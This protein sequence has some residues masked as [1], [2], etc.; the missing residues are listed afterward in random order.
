M[1]LFPHHLDFNFMKY[2]YIS[3]GISL[4]LMIFASIVWFQKGVEK[5]GVEFAGGTELIIQFP[6]PVD[7]ALVRHEIENAGFPSATVQA[8]EDGSHK[9]SIR[10][11]AEPGGDAGKKIR[12][13]LK[14]AWKDTEFNVLDE[15]FVGPTIGEQLRKDGFTAV[16]VSLFCILVYIWVRFDFSFAVG[17]VAALF[18]DTII[19]S[20]LV[21]FFGREV[22]A[23][24]LAAV[25]TIIGYSVNDTV[26]VFDRI[27]ENFNKA[28]KSGGASKKKDK[29][30][31][32]L[33]SLMNASINQTLNRTI[34]T[35]A[36]VSFVCILLWLLGDGAV[37]DLAF[38]LTIGM[39]FGTYSSIFTAAPI[40]LEWRRWRG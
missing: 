14:S 6:R 36:T 25:L 1:E 29:D 5:Y 26:I 34:I 31:L 3:I 2:R 39:F 18:H 11:K 8:F 16:I 17:A 20:G 27:R 19:T 10:L 15:H 23:A 33:P 35:N 21:V 4:L 24:L 32:D 12:D 13:Q 7:P 37:S 40:A 28:L 22:N 30:P 9:F 38:A